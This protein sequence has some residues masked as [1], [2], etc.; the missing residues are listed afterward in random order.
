MNKQKLTV[1]MSVYNG[2]PHLKQS[3]ESILNQTYKDFCFLIINDGSIDNSL[4]YLNS[5]KDKRVKIISQTNKG[6]GAALNL[7]LEHIQTKYIARMD[8]D[9]IARPKRL[10]LQIHKMETDKNIIMLGTGISYTVDGEKSGFSPPM[11]LQHHQIK[12]IL[13]KGGH[14]ISHATIVCRT[15]AIKNVGAY[16]VTGVGQDWDLF[17]RMSEYG[18][19]A[20][21]REILLHVRLNN[22]SNAWKFSDEVIKGKYFA[23]ECANCRIKGMPEPS[24]S[25]FHKK[26]DAQNFKKKV[27]RKLMMISDQ[28]YRYAVL[29]WLQGRK[30]KSLSAFLL[31]AFLNPQKVILYIKRKLF[32]IR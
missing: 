12:S 30:I 18:K 26:W 16:R 13:L 1:L 15:E 27:L 20:N 10:Q 29:N 17:L 8:A 7:G 14:A 28:L 21:L 32:L 9:D 24:I 23:L 5:I 4:D 22:K 25:E 2:M 6:L 3:V 19:I 31:S 11:P